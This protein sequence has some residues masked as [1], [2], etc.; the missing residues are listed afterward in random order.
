MHGARAGA[1]CSERE[2][3]MVGGEGEGEATSSTGELEGWDMEDGRE[4]ADR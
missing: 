1:W 2:E 4:G 3:G